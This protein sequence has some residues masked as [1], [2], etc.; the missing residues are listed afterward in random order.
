MGRAT[1]KS[2]SATKSKP[3]SLA[4]AFARSVLG[5]VPAEHRE[6]IRA[7]LKA[8][9]VQ[10]ALDARADRERSAKV[11]KMVRQI[12][13]DLAAGKLVTTAKR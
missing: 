5:A 6:R 9:K 7:E 4:D 11:A 3:T 13:S 10:A 1:S 12:A 2:K 8:H